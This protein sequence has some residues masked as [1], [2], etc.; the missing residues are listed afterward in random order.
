MT[1]LIKISKGILKGI[2]RFLEAF[3]IFFMFYFSVMILGTL[4][5]TGEIFDEGDYTIYVISNGVHTDVCLPVK[6]ESMDW[7]T[8]VPLSDYPEVNNPKY[9]RIGWGDKGFFLD[10]PTWDDLT[11]KTALNAAV[12]PSG[13]AMH[14][15]YEELEPTIGDRCR[16]LYIPKKNYADLVDYILSSF[17]TTNDKPILIPNSGYWENDNFYEAKGNYHLFNT[18]NTWTNEALQV[19]G[20]RTGAHVLFQD[21]ILYHLP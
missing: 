14:V 4:I 11:L 16:Q 10:T 20:I 9:V 1:L 3:L 17:K 12:L 7:E 19:A 6:T 15:E 18:C 21:G 8:F 13:T 5:P 2:T